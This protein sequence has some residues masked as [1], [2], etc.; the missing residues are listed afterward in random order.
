MGPFALHA[1]RSGDDVRVRLARFDDHVGKRGDA[2]M[3]CPA[4][5]FGQLLRAL[6]DIMEK[7][8]VAEIVRR[9]LR[10]AVA[11]MPLAAAPEHDRLAFVKREL[12][13]RLS[14][15]VRIAWSQSEP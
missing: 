11:I 14:G 2:E 10:D 9:S 15:S 6:W 7:Y 13:N 12:S 5:R 8:Q 4:P 1:P 3:L